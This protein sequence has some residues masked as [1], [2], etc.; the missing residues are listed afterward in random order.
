METVSQQGEITA[1]DYIATSGEM[2]LKPNL[3]GSEVRNTLFI[4]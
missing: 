1:Q 4:A 3:S 2:G